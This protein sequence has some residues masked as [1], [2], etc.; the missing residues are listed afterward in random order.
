MLNS[1]LLLAAFSRG[2]CSI[3]KAAGLPDIKT[4]LFPRFS[5]YIFSLISNMIICD[6]VF[7]SEARSHILSARSHLFF[8]CPLLFIMFP[9]F[10]SLHATQQVFGVL[11]LMFFNVAL[12]QHFLCHRKIGVGILLA[13]ERM[14]VS[15][16]EEDLVNSQQERA[17]GY[18][19]PAL[20]LPSQ[21]FFWLLSHLVSTILLLQ[22]FLFR[23]WM[24][25]AGC[26]TSA[27]NGK[28]VNS[29]NTVSTPD[30]PTAHPCMTL[31]RHQTLHCVKLMEAAVSVLA[32]CLII[33]KVA[34][35]HC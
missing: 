35:I 19:N 23:S 29:T 17:Y 16:H 10:F 31:N 13:R 15:S 27:K 6:E 4:F 9:P 3:I 18:L 33:C 11:P 1:L 20:A 21:L 14:Y 30:P 12:L 7:A 8:Y 26:A 22:I 32:R 25:H 24:R 28:N 2:P 34:L 5:R